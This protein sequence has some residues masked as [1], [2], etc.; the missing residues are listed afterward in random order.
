M[1]NRDGYLGLDVSNVAQEQQPLKEGV[2]EFIYLSLSKTSRWRQRQEFSELP[3]IY[4]SNT[5]F[6][7]HVRNFR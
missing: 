6:R 7:S 3:K 2:E 5:Q 1:G 4:R